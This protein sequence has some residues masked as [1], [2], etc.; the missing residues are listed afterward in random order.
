MEK[1]ISAIQVAYDL[2]VLDMKPFQNVWCLQ[3]SQGKKCLKKV[4]YSKEDA[5]FIWLATENL[6]SNSYNRFNRFTLTKKNEPFLEFEKEIYVLSD[7]IEGQQSDY[8]DINNL[9]IAVHTLNDLHKASKGFRPP[10][11]GRQRI[12]WGYWIDN[13]EERYQELKHFKKLASQQQDTFF[14]ELFNMNV[15]YHIEDAKEAIALLKKSTYYDLVNE[16]SRLNGF[17]HHDYAY[18]NVLINSNEGFLIDFDY[19]ICDLRCHDVASLMMRSIKDN[20]WINKH[21]EYVLEEYQR[22]AGLRKGETN[23]MY[24]FLKFPQEFWQAGYTYYI[25]RNRPQ[26]RMEKR[27]KNCVTSM[28]MRARCLRDLAEVCCER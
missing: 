14:D 22:I 5:V 1:I 13:F 27:L 11:F 3:T 26:E 12:K 10:A 15:D 2:L 8:K 25:E 16:E 20:N 21:A 6:I 9:T 17:C 24:A 19:I 18:H 7:W 23:V 4:K 28:E